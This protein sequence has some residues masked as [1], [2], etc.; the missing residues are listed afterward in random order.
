[1]LVSH[2]YATVLACPPGHPTL[3][4][5]RKIFLAGFA[6]LLV[7]IVWMFM[8]VERLEDGMSSQ[9]QSSNTSNQ[10]QS[11][12]KAYATQAAL[13]LRQSQ[14]QNSLRATQQAEDARQ[15]EMWDN[16]NRNQD[17]LREA[18]DAQLRKFLEVE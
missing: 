11:L 16:F 6:V 18:S 14:R 17:A 1:M 5:E 10:S 4:N 15:R 12:P 7:I 3:T 2:G 13:D 8:R 9:S